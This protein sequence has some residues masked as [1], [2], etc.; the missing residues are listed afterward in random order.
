[1][2][3]PILIAMIIDFALSSCNFCG[4]AQLNPH[5]QIYDCD[6]ANDMVLVTHFTGDMQRSYARYEEEICRIL[7]S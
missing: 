7:R 6:F 5:R 3:S 1:M 2:R 4:G